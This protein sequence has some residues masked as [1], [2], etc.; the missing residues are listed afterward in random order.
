MAT[1]PVFRGTSSDHTWINWQLYLNGFAPQLFTRNDGLGQTVV[2]EL[3][4]SFGPLLLSKQG[5]AVVVVYCYDRTSGRECRS[6]QA[7]GNCGDPGPRPT[8]P[9][10]PFSSC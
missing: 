9:R 2:N 10:P 5:R 6:D 1:N 7:Q 3:G 8:P 4:P